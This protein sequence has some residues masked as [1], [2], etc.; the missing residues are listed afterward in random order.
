MICSGAVRGDDETRVQKK[1]LLNCKDLLW[2]RKYL[3]LINM[4]EELDRIQN[5]LVQGE[6]VFQCLQDGE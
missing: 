6:F 2:T 5:L 4:F 3:D 1:R